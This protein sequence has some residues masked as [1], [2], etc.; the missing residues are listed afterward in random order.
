MK[1]ML[2]LNEQMIDAKVCAINES[3]HL[4]QIEV[5]TEK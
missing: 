5:K 4:P 2:A 3:L 1:D